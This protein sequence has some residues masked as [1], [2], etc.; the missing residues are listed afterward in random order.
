MKPKLS[1]T[2]WGIEQHEQQQPNK[3]HW[4]GLHDQDEDAAGNRFD[5]ATGKLIDNSRAT[6]ERLDR[7]AIRL[8]TKPSGNGDLLGGVNDD[9][10]YRGL[11]EA[12]KEWL[13]QNK[14]TIEKGRK[15]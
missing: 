5:D 2:R 15:E 8:S 11:D 12:A 4:G 7:L 10:E 14:E 13:R 6:T 9:P 1:E 3:G